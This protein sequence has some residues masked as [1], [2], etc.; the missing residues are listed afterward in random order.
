[1]G[2]LVRSFRSSGPR[3]RTPVGDQ[4]IPEPR[5]AS[6]VWTGVVLPTA[7][8]RAAILVLDPDRGDGT[9]ALGV[10]LDDGTSAV[11]PVRWDDP[12][13]GIGVARLDV[14][15]SDVHGVERR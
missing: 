10:T 5:P 11:V 8:D 3:W 13:V 9:D 15:R 7:A 2:P 6:D 12:T 4:C 1:M 14:S